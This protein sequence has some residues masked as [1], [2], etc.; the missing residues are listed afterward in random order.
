MLVLVAV[1]AAAVE[2]TAGIELA[3]FSRADAV[4]V[5]D[6]RRTGTGVGEFDGTVWPSM[7]AYGGAWLSERVGLTGTLGV[8]R[9]TTTTYVNEA[10]QSRHVGV[11][12]PGA[13]LRVS[14]LK[15]SDDRPRPYALLGFHGT[16]PSA[17]NAGSSFSPEE[18]DEA[19]RDASVERAR[20]G[21]VGGRL[22][23]GVDMRVHKHVS[24]GFL[25]TGQVHRAVIRTTEAASVTGWVGSEAAFTLAFEWPR[26]GTEDPD[27]G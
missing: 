7:R 19:R 11:F 8:A 25:W 2:P 20:L 15:R 14:F 23:V 9:L 12:R 18:R 22:G 21:G 10:W 24:A 13:D 16:I 17:R 3:P 4:Q 6:G 1:V 26:R 27:E 5:A